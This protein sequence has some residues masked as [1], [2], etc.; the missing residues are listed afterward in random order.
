VQGSK[1][2]VKYYWDTIIS[3]TI[4]K[5]AMPAAAPKGAPRQPQ[6]G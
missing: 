3:F 4:L 5:I 2:I 6:Y 1:S